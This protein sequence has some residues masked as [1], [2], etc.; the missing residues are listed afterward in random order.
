MKTGKR[1]T[2]RT[3]I[4]LIMLATGFGSS[5]MSCFPAGKEP[6]PRKPQPI[7]RPSVDCST[8]GGSCVRHGQKG[9]CIQGHC[10]LGLGHCSYD[11]DCGDGSDCT[12]DVCNRGR[13]QTNPIS[14]GTC[15]TTRGAVGSCADGICESKTITRCSADA[16]CPVSGR[17]CIQNQCIGGICLGRPGA[18]GESCQEPSGRGGSCIAGK[19]ATTTTDTDTC[20]QAFDPYWGSYRQCSTGLAYTLSTDDIRVAEQKITKDLSSELRYDVKVALVALPDGGYNIVVFNRRPR[21][22]VRGLCDPSFVA[23]NVAFYTARSKWKSRDLQIWLK[24][25]EE[26]WSLPTSGSREA[27]RRGMAK[28]GFGWLGVVNVPEFRQWLEKSFRPLIA[29]KAFTEA[30]QTKRPQGRRSPTPKSN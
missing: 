16:E 28:S 10:I 24:A 15:S 14:G 5:T 30:A 6:E 2:L 4:A 12:T 19:C 29:V 8:E 11:T 27:I 1:N 25:Y 23:F 7:H 22:E 21:S 3:T 9:E 13:C 20:V 18:D 26:G 17:P